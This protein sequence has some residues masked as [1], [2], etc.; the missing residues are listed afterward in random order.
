LHSSMRPSEE[1]VQH[2]SIAT[3]VKVTPFGRRYAP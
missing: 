3:T 2:L 1:S